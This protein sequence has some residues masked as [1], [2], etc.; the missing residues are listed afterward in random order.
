[1]FSLSTRTIF[2]SVV[3]ASTVMSAPLSMI[4][5]TGLAKRSSPKGW[6]CAYDGPSTPLV[7]ASLNVP[8]LVVDLCLKV[9]F[10]HPGCESFRPHSKPR[11]DTPV[12]ITNDDDDDDEAEKKKPSKPHHKTSKPS[13]SKKDQPVHSYSSDDD[14]EDDEPKHKKHT[15]KHQS[16]PHDTK[17]H[18]ESLDD[19]PE[20]SNDSTCSATQRFS[21]LVSAC[22]DL[23][24]FSEP[25]DQNTCQAGQMDSLLNLCLDVSLLGNG[26]PV[27]S[28]VADIPPI[29]A[30]ADD[31]LDSILDGDTEQCKSTQKYSSLVGGC[32]EQSSCSEPTSDRKCDGNLVLDKLLGLCINLDA[33]LG[34]LL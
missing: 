18:T 8:G 15:T 16:H 31:H 26:S 34:G 10:D 22:V 17:V 33:H 13:S 7:D 29:Q 25:N 28:V 32:V 1:M 19:E 11:H 24:L 14:D 2:L 9:L 21:S 4:A 30:D 3:L 23:N 12:H 6:T 27:A 5:P 20:P